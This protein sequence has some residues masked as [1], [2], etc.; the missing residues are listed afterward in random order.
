MFSLW[1]ECA[2]CDLLS[3]NFEESEQLMAELRRRGA[4]KLDQAAVYHLSIQLHAV[5]GEYARAVD[6]GLACLRL[7]GIDLP[8]HPTWEQ[9]QA[10]YEAVWQTLDGRS[11][12][13]LIDLPLMNDPEL[14]AAM[15]VFLDLTPAAYLTDFHLSCLQICRVVKLSMQY[16]TSGASAHAY[17]YLGT[18]LGPVFHRYSDAYRLA[19]LGCDLVRSTALSP[20][21]RTSTMRWEGSPFGRSQL[22]PRSTSCGRTLAP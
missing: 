20:T 7:L 11:I 4:S 12:E 14:K 17:G 3:G 6:T 19:K 9:V 18:I 1:L 5:K 22:R 13:S 16:G 10:E 15:Q 21:V 8:A 2:Q